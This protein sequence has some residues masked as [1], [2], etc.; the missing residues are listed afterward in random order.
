MDSHPCILFIYWFNSW[1][2]CLQAF[3]LAV[4]FEQYKDTWE[5]AYRE[6]PPRRAHDDDLNT[7]VTYCPLQRLDL[8]WIQVEKISYSQA[9]IF[10]PFHFS[11]IQTS[12]TT[13]CHL[14]WRSFPV[15]NTTHEWHE[16]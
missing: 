3:T 10:I 2:R 5:R 8:V 4:F 11:F 9:V 13:Y 1:P 15:P 14:I 16:V 12:R 7:V 6:L